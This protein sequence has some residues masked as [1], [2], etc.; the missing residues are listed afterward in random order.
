MFIPLIVVLALLAPS[1][2][3]AQDT[4]DVHLWLQAVATLN[5]SENWRLHL[6]DPPRQFQNVTEPFQII[7][8][9]GVG[10]RVTP[11]LTLWAGH[12]WVAKPPGPDVAHEQRF[13]QQASVTFPALGAWTPSVRLRNEQ[14]WQGGWADSSHRLRMMNRFVRPLAEGSRWS[15]ATFNELM[16]TF[17][18]T[19]RGPAQGIDQNRL[20]GGLSYRF[21]PQETLEFGTIY[22]ATR[23]VNSPN[24]HAIVPFVWM[25]L[26]Y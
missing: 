18:E 24:T 8:R 25:N 4:I 12:A 6:E 26:T 17:D 19:S 21:S 20:F 7:T 9:T 13:W 16:L 1:R 22:V 15:I 10:R 11:R 2:A 5:V 3:L 23:A 14:R